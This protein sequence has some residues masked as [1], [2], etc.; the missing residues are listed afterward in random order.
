MGYWKKNIVI[1]EK[2]EIKKSNG[3]GDYIKLTSDEQI[4]ELLEDYNIVILM[5]NE[6][7]G[8]KPF[9]LLLKHQ[10]SIDM[11]KQ[12]LEKNKNTREFTI[13]PAK[14]EHYIDI[15]K[16]ENEYVPDNIDDL[17][18][19]KKDLMNKIKHDFT[20]KIDSLKT[21]LKDELE[22]VENAYDKQIE[23]AREENKRLEN[24]EVSKTTEDKASQD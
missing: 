13:V 2:L 20:E 8:L 24:E 10:I 6:G 11:L 22:K 9:R 21:N 7:Y 19:K 1:N 16:V 12:E 15:A 5:S 14:S 3:I 4:K 17:Q 23:Q 18:K